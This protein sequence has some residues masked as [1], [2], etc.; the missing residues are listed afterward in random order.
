M[1]SIVFYGLSDVNRKIR[2]ASVSNSSA[3]ARLLIWQ[4][5]VISTIAR[6]DWPDE[7]PD[8]LSSLIAL[9]NGGNPDSV[10]GAMSVV[11]EFARDDLS[12]EQLLPVIRDLAPSLL[13]I[14]G[15]REASR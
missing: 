9:L 12:E 2:S 13:I 8:L 14:L 11:A 4:A 5:F 3:Y 7:W 6:Y 15:N 1:R 10:N